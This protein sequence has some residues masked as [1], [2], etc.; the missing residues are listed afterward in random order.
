M[1]KTSLGERQSN[2]DS[3]DQ[4]RGA[5]VKRLSSTS[6]QPP[7]TTKY[8]NNYLDNKNL[9]TSNKNMNNKNVNTT[10]KNE[11]TPKSNLNLKNTKEETKVNPITIKKSTAKDLDL[12]D[13]DLDDI[14]LEDLDLDDLDLDLDNNKRSAYS[15]S[16]SR[17][18]KFI[19]TYLIF[20]CICRF[21]LN[22]YLT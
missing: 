12:D 20:F 6:K 16:L 10:N 3:P 14:N 13:I 21:H 9:N 2:S 11:V 5:D 19:K 15:S 4:G 7:D 18:Q 22:A 8:S 17:Y 1:F